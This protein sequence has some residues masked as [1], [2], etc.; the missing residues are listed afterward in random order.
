MIWYSV[1][2]IKKLILFNYFP[3]TF[4]YFYILS[5]KLGAFNKALFCRHWRRCNSKNRARQL[6][7]CL[8]AM[9]RSRCVWGV[10]RS[11]RVMNGISEWCAKWLWLIKNLQ[12]LC[13]HVAW[14]HSRQTTTV[15]EYNSLHAKK[16]SRI[17]T[18]SP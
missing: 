12:S 8:A 13:Q 2:N 15:W 10:H 6:S 5:L 9:L 11:F 7:N 14:I 1:Q 4:H 17:C 18:S 3:C 16:K